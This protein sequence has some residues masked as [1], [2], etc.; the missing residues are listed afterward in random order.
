M[1]NTNEITDGITTGVEVRKQRGLQIAALAK[2][3]KVGGCYI[4][5]S[6][7]SR[8]PTKYKVV[9][10]SGHQTC[11]C[12]DHELRACRCKHIYAVEYYIQRE[13]NTDGSTTVTETVTVTKTRQTYPQ[14]WTAYN[15][16]QTNEKAK[17]QSLLADLSRDVQTPE[18]SG[19]GRDRMT[20]S[21]AIFS[22]AFKVYH[23]MICTPFN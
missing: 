13:H 14:N 15:E 20:L 5:P 19:R 11:T 3:E 17:F 22:S 12:P 4:V 23:T 16:A 18:Q 21:D 10:S 7:F 2:N 6:Q 1:L 9:Y 8:N